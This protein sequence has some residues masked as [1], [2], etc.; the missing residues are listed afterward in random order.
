M[1][2]YLNI[3]LPKWPQL[4]IV[5]DPVT[6]EQAKDIIFRMDPFLTDTYHLSG[7]NDRIFNQQYR[8]Q[9]GLSTSTIDADIL[10]SH[11]VPETSCL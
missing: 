10:K 1:I 8:T 2:D 3:D 7:G 11:P 9:A 4:L 5:G 6:I